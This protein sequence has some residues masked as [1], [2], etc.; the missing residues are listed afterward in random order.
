MELEL[1]RHKIFRKL[2]CSGCTVS[3]AFWYLCVAHFSCYDWWCKW[4]EQQNDSHATSLQCHAGWTTGLG[5][6]NTGQNDCD[7]SGVLAEGPWTVSPPH[8]LCPA[9]LCARHE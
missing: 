8:K 7:F 1:L 4:D 5:V 9:L 3:L 6:Y 2:K